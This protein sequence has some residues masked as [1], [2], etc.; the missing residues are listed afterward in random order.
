ML[1]RVADNLYWMARYLARA[2]ATARLLDVNLHETL[3]QAPASFVHRWQRL[4]RTLRVT[5]P[6]GTDTD[7]LAMTRLLAFDPRN[8]DSIASCIANSRENMRQVR[9]QTSTE[10]WEHLNRLYLRVRETTLD[11]I[12]GADV[13]RFFQRIKEGAFLFQGA[14]DATMS[15]DEGWLFIQLGRHLEMASTTASL[16]DVTFGDYQA[17]RGDDDPLFSYFDW[18][19]LLKSCSAF[20]AYS[21]THTASLQPD[22]ILEFLLLS[23]DFPRSLCFCAASVEQALREIAVLAG[24]SG[25]SGRAERLAGRL[26]ANLDFS[27]ADEIL[28]G[29]LH[30]TLDDIRRNCALIHT[31][32]YQAYIAYPVEAALGR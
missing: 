3:E 24:H 6:P 13:H 1:S 23:R 30:A 32:V 18:A 7:S 5:A 9:E 2:E 4:L 14:T 25:K 12:W 21:K 17:D 22:R 31:A 29:D 19:C 11:D 10:M 20:E 8:R 28:S 27:L 16:L 26:R 15:H